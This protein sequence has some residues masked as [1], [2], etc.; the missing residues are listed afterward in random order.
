MK[1][2]LLVISVLLLA[3]LAC[4]VTEKGVI[5]EDTSTPSP[6][7]LY[8]DD[9]SDT[10]SGWPSSTDADGITDYD[11]GYY[12]IRVDT[13]GSEGNGMDIWVSS[14]EKLKADVYIDVTV[15][16]AAG[17]DDNDMGVLC[18]YTK[19]DDAF[20][21]YYFLITSDGYAAIE[22]M[23]AGS[24]EIISGKEMAQSSAI[25]KTGV[26]HI[27]AECIGEKLTLFVNGIRV[28]S[29]TDDEFSDGT[30]GLIAGTFS[31][32]GVDIHFDDLM[33][34]EP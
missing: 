9:F 5:F 21:F 31:T 16:K 26:N 18:R 15:T 29:A 25:K 3:S 6:K 11:S 7:I 33:V 13:I 27:R 8:Q 19:K 22:K 32:P 34:T 17:P 14:R 24:S 10:S 23:K 2:L 12:R 1:K 4:K 20:Y 28:A 30:I